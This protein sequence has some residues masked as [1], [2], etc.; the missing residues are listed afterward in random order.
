MNLIK[1]QDDFSSFIR[2]VE[3][4]MLMEGTER[5]YEAQV[6]EG[7]QVKMRNVVTAEQLWNRNGLGGMKL[8][9]NPS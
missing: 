1:I 9:N 2:V 3:A 8:I 6:Q 7:K 4:G 5:A